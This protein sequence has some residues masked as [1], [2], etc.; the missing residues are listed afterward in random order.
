[1]KQDK[2]TKAEKRWLRNFSR[3]FNE[4]AKQSAS[5]VSSSRETQGM[6]V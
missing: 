6:R 5:S 3:Q 1:M 2:K 4:S